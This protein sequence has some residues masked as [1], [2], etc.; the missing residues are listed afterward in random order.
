M[1]EIRNEDI[2]A[3]LA[4]AVNWRKASYSQGANEC[5][6]VASVSRAFGV[7]DSKPGTNSPILVFNQESWLTF[8]AY[9]KNGYG[10]N[11]TR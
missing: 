5:V 10:S 9:T 6:E 8:I 11:V 2:V 3:A 7:R 4:I 1:I